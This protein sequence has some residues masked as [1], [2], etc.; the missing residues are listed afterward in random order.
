MIKLIINQKL[1][2]IQQGL[3]VFQGQYQTRYDLLIAATAIAIIPLIAAY[4]VF[5]KQILQ[6]VAEGAVKG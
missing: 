1:M 3:L 4:V 2:P 5:N 6:G